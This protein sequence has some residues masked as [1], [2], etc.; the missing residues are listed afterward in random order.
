MT[1]DDGFD[2]Q[3]QVGLFLRTAFPVMAEI[4]ADMAMLIGKMSSKFET[5]SEAVTRLEQYN[6]SVREYLIIV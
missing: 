3:S 1:N 6:Q 4:P 2:A 5:I